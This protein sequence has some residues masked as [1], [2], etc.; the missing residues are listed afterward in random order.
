LNG[1]G[2][3]TDGGNLNGAHIDSGDANGVLADLPANGWRD[4]YMVP[5]WIGVRQLFDLSMIQLFIIC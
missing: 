4:G 3:Y 2:A 5:G 1:S